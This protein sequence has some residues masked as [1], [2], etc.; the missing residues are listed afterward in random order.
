VSA[1]DAE[2]RSCFD[3]KVRDSFLKTC[4]ECEDK[5]PLVY[6]LL[7]ARCFSDASPIVGFKLV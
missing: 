2:E 3:E 4:R 5:N 1:A 6:D 7:F